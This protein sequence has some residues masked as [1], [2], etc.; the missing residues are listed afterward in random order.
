MELDAA[1]LRGTDVVVVDTINARDVGMSAAR[2]MSQW[3]CG[4]PHVDDDDA[5]LSIPTFANSHRMGF[6][7]LRREIF[8]KSNRGSL[9]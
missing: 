5:S 2:G 8:I 1:M 3:R 7:L 4:C 9:L 6:P